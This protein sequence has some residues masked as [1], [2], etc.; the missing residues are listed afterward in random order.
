MTDDTE[1]ARQEA[2]ATAICTAIETRVWATINAQSEWHRL[3]H[4]LATAL[5][6]LLLKTLLAMAATKTADVNF[7]LRL[8]HQIESRFIAETTPDVVPTSH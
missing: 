5:A 8:L 4:V 3:P 1:R 2:E 6:N 7:G